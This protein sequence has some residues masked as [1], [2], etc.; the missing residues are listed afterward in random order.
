MPPTYRPQFL[1]LL[2]SPLLGAFAG[3]VVATVLVWG[4]ALTQA[5]SL[6]VSDLATGAVMGLVL[7]GIYGGIAGAAVGA[8]LAIP[9]V[10]LVGRH[11]P[12]DV[13][14]RR[15]YV[16]G[17]VL[18][19][20]ILLAGVV[21]LLDARV[22]WPEGEEFWGLLPLAGAAITG[23]RLAGWLAGMDDVERPVS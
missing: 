5:G 15:A 22:S 19:P 17:A 6:T 16:L 7:G 20:V 10:F 13:A 11:L 3:A 21:V 8:V 2:F 9:L 18:P 12:R 4:V 23:S 1:W 14:R